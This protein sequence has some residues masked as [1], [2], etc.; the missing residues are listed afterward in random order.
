MAAASL[1]GLAAAAVFLAE[2]LGT[3]L[4]AIGRGFG[5]GTFD[6]AQAS[7]VHADTATPKTRLVASAV[8][9]N[10]AAREEEVTA[11]PDGESFNRSSPS[12][13]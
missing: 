4:R 9:R 1:A 13:I 10:A 11:F 2:A 3:T 8:D 5:K 6:L 7:A 12:S